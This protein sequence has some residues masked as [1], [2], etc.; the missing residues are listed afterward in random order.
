MGCHVVYFMV[1]STIGEENHILWRLTFD[2]KKCCFV[3]PD[4]LCEYSLDPFTN[5]CINFYFGAQ[6]K[7]D[8]CTEW[9]VGY[10]SQ[11]H[12][13]LPH[14]Y[15]NSSR[16]GTMQSILSQI[17][18]WQVRSG[19]SLHQFVTITLISQKTRIE[20]LL[21]GTCDIHLTGYPVFNMYVIIVGYPG[22]YF[23][24]QDIAFSM[25]SKFV[26]Y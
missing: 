24:S 1:W 13:I 15:G 11:L 12:N 16:V 10:F 21:L 8:T 6:L 22:Y 19:D 18:Q 20:I 5:S 25:R 17:S 4:N 9:Y 7:S 23:T 26:K 14:H 2:L 3:F